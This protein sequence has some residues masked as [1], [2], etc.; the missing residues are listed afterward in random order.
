MLLNEL[1]ASIQIAALVLICV[2]TRS[3]SDAIVEC[4]FWCMLGIFIG[5]V[6]TE[7]NKREQAGPP[8]PAQP[9]PK[10]HRGLTFPCIESA[11]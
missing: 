7:I 2:A 10:I 8:V 6:I 4:T 9:T 11:Y 1:K 5:L 3:P